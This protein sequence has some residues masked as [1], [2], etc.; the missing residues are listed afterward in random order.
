MLQRALSA[1]ADVTA[2][3]DFQTAR[4]H[5][6]AMPPDLLITNLRLQAYNGLHPHGARGVTDSGHRVD[7]FRRMRRSHVLPAPLARL[8][9]RRTGSPRPRSHGLA[10]ARRCGSLEP[11]DQGVIL[12]KDCSKTRLKPAA[13]V[14]PRPVARLR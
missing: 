3:G 13:V 1:V 4:H 10:Q 12:E 8:S 5:I 6:L 9:K 11:A 14:T 2:C 7:G